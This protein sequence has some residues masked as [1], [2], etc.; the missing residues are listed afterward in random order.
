MLDY[1]GTDLRR[2]NIERAPK[3]CTI[4]GSLFLATYNAVLYLR[5]VNLATIQNFCVYFLIHKFLKPLAN[6]GLSKKMASCKTLHL[7]FY[8]IRIDT[9]NRVVEGPIDILCRCRDVALCV[10]NWTCTEL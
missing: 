4:L 9:R 8:P 6:L 7:T 3:L 1:L 10:D 2:S 5:D